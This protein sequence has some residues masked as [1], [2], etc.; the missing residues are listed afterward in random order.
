MSEETRERKKNERKEIYKYIEILVKT[1]LDQ[2]EYPAQKK[3]LLVLTGYEDNILRTG[4]K[5]LLRHGLI[6]AAKT[7]GYTARPVPEK[8]LCWLHGR[9]YEGNAI[10]PKCK[11]AEERQIARIIE[12]F[13][14]REKRRDIDA[15]TKY[16]IK[17]D[18][19]QANKRSRGARTARAIRRD[20]SFVVGVRGQVWEIEPNYKCLDEEE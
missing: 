13:K 3:E 16:R 9:Y 2:T 11:R 17:R 15:K 20:A 18:N 8:G 1:R 12:K 5:W 19:L 10:C 6:E 4:L 7:V 14:N